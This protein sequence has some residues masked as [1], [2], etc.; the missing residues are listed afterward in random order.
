MKNLL[1]CFKHSKTFAVS[2]VSIN[3]FISFELL[4]YNSASQPL[5]CDPKVN[6]RLTLFRSML[7][8]LV[9][10]SL[11]V[12]AI[13]SVKKSGS[14]EL[15]SLF[16][17]NIW[18]VTKKVEKHWSTTMVGKPWLAYLLFAARGNVNYEDGC[19]H[20]LISPEEKTIFYRSLRL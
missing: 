4:I 18:V 8:C 12:L 16:P 3:R 10:S 11:L 15:C 6:L 14:P 13:K 1:L 2:T 7:N 20:R 19:L 17:L 9:F 5:S